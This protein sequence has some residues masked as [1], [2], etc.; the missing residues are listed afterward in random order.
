M[1]SDSGFLHC[2]EVII[3]F[4]KRLFLPNAEDGISGFWFCD[5]LAKPDVLC[6]NESVELDN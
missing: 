4:C 1:P 6:Y 5:I 3:V 2:L